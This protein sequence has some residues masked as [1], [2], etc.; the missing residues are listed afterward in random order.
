MDYGVPDGPDAVTR[1]PR[2]GVPLAMLDKK[3]AAKSIMSPDVVMHGN[4]KF[5]IRA[6]KIVGHVSFTQAM[7][8][9]LAAQFPEADPGLLPLGTRILV[10]IQ[11]EQTKSQGGLDLPDEVKD[12]LKWNEQTCRVIA[13]GPLAYR[14]PNTGEAYAEGNWCNP[15]DFI[16]VP[17][18]SGD[19]S[20]VLLPNGEKA[21]FVVFNDREVISKVTGDPLSFR[22]R[23]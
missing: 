2:G 10:Q 1:R 12:R 21:L 11:K 3:A 9:E 4:P 15:G 19:K 20:E 6:L 13:L 8:E 17:K 23:L 16:R 14:N 5:P 22:V 18:Y 7:A